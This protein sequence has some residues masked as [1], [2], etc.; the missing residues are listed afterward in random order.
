MASRAGVL[1]SGAGMPA[2]LLSALDNSKKDAGKRDVSRWLRGRWG[3]WVACFLVRPLL[4]VI[5]C[6]HC[7]RLAMVWPWGCGWVPE[8]PGLL[9]LSVEGR[10]CGGRTRLARRR[11]PPASAASLP[12]GLL[13]H[14]GKAVPGHQQQPTRVRPRL[15]ARRASPGATS[16]AS[17]APGA[18][19]GNADD[20]HQLLASWTRYEAPRRLDDLGNHPF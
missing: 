11:A 5:R 7:A 16:H 14:C 18:K 2:S 6:W 13:P 15:L 12:G 4:A 17:P 20:S 19:H 1:A 9:L 10:R 8:G 3:F